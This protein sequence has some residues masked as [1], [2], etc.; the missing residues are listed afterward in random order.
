M[1]FIVNIL[2]VSLVLVLPWT[3]KLIPESSETG[4]ITTL[5]E[6][7]T[8]PLPH[9]KAIVERGTDK[10][11]AIVY[12][13]NI[14][15]K[16][17]DKVFLQRDPQFD[18]L[19]SVT[20]L[21]RTPA[22]MQLFALF[23]MVILIVSREAGIRSLLG[24]LF[25]FAVIFRF[26]LPQ[27]AAGANPLTIALMASVLI[28]LVSYFLTHGVNDKSIIAILGTF[29]ALAIT[30]ILAMIYGSSARISGFGSEEVSFLIGNLEAANFYNLY[31]AGIIIGSLGVL[32]DI[33]ISQA[34]IVSE[35]SKANHRL[36]ILELYKRAMNI[37]HDHISS[38]VNT[39][40]LVY[41]GS[42][43]PLLLLFVASNASVMEL[44]NYEA[45][46]E[47]IV[48]TLVGSIG[49]VSAV[50]LT[51]AIAAYWYGSKR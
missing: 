47:E 36:S 16:I 20:D 1:K 33:T 27:I 50:P 4:V 14:A 15:Y 3:A 6:S 22:L 40:V 9:K 37:G 18:G 39:L 29:G 2:I 44:L 12:E 32:D 35:L 10:V 51:T 43:L 19:Y 30:G 49:L 24:L 8:D 21:V 34:S 28:L 38:L 41:A 11:E 31:L 13:S 26:V 17:G 23:I 48:R 42:A 25:S 5:S 45:V 7:V 46:A